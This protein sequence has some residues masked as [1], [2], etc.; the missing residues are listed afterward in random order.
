[1]LHSFFKNSVVKPINDTKKSMC[2]IGIVAADA[3]EEGL[4]RPSQF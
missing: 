1:M 4:P 2:I 3:I